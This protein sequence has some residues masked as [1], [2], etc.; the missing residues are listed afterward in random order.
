MLAAY[1]ISN[2]VDLAGKPITSDSKLE[3]TNAMVRCVLARVM[4]FN[5]AYFL[6]LTGFAPPF[7]VTFK[8]RIPESM[9]DESL[10]DVEN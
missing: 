4:C 8:P 7:K 1:E 5:M 2:P 10:L 9:I 3:F 6:R